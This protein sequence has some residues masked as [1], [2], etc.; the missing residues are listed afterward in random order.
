MRI[1]LLKLTITLSLGILFTIYSLNGSTVRAFSAGPLPGNTGAPGEF[2]CASCH[3]GGPS[4][5]T[6]SISGLPANYSI[7]QEVTLTVTL[8]QANRGRYGFQLTAIDDS[9]KQAGDL[10]PND[11]RTQLRTANVLGNLRQYIEHTFGGISP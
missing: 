3:S 8:S 2:T 4:G 11:S 7:N 1:H 9:G 10:T 5:G 6:L